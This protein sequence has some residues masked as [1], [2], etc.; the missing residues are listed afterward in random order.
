MALEYRSNL[1]GKTLR[2]LRGE[3]HRHTEL[4][5]DGGADGSLEDMWRYALDAAGMDWLG[6]G[7]HY[8]GE[9]EY[10][11]WLIQKTST[12]FQ[13][14]GTF[15]P[16]YTYERNVNYPDGHR[17]PVFAERACASADPGKGPGQDHGPTARRPPPFVA[18][19]AHVVSLPGVL[20]R[21]LRVAYLR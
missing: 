10:F 20:R 3:F 2:V 19:H 5:P 17:N 14:P 9:S 11:W 12:V 1:A 6:N 15:T 4:S 7:E 8:A 13:L 21:D 18:R 16:M